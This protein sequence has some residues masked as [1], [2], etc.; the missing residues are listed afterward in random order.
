[1]AQYEPNNTDFMRYTYHDEETFE[2]KIR[3]DAPSE[4]K[5]EFKRLQTFLKEQE[6]NESVD[7]IP[8]TLDDDD[9]GGDE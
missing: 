6:E 7:F 9:F 8:P 1:M 3:D 5:E 4:A 2:L